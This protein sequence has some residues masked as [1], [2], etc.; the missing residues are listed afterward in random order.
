MKPMLK[1][2]DFKDVEIHNE[3]KYYFHC[4]KEVKKVIK[5]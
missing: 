4:K 2:I 5:T 1:L 3:K